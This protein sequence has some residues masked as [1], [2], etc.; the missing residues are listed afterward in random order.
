[1]N[2][3]RFFV[4]CT[5]KR[6]LSAASLRHTRVRFNY[7]F[8][9]LGEKK[10]NPRSAESFV[11]HLREKGLRNASING[12]IRVL[13]LV[14]AFER[15]NGKD[16]NLLK[17]IDYF[18]KQRR[19]P[20]ILSIDEVEALLQTKFCPP[21]K[22]GKKGG[23]LGRKPAYDERTFKLSLWVLVSTGCRFDEMASLKKENLF[24]GIGE[25]WVEFRDTKTLDDRKVPIPPLLVEMLKEYLKNKSP[26]DL[27]FVS[28]SGNKLVEQTWNPYLRLHAQNAGLSGKHI[29]AHCFRNSY[30]MEHLRRGTD[31]LTIAK[32]VGHRDVN[33]TLGYTKYEYDDLLRGAENHPLFSK[34]LTTQKIITKIKEAVEKWPVKNDP[35]FELKVVSSE[36]RLAVE[37]VAKR[38]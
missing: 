6:H 12:Y 19:V 15:E 34:S 28:S 13:K 7:F 38:V 16:L 17:L 23:I 3:E 27:V 4:W 33:T 2:K 36:N 29:H 8:R 22:I 1:M 24:L 32:L 31:P 30:I 9:W 11:L 25:G 10:L 14:D 5:V 21:V 37:I 26:T 20:T 18:P 35:R